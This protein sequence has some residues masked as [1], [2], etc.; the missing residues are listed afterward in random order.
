MVCAK[1]VL[2]SDRKNRRAVNNA[3]NYEDM[4]Y[5][6]IIVSTHDDVKVDGEP[7]LHVV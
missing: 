4:S 3:S 7:T 2:C 6:M 1:D 5:I